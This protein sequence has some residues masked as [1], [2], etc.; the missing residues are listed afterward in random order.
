[1]VGREKQEHQWVSMLRN[2]RTSWIEVQKREPR[3]VTTSGAG[4]VRVSFEVVRDNEIKQLILK[5]LTCKHSNGYETT[6]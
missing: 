2:A 4:S 3:R 5:R 1:M 6:L